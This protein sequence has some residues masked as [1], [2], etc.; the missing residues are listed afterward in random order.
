[1]PTPKYALQVVGLL[2]GLTLCAWI[3]PN[4]AQTTAL[5]N[6]VSGM[7]FMYNRGEAEVVRDDYGQIGEIRP[8][9]P[10]PF[11]LTCAITGLIWLGAFIRTNQMMAMLPSTPPRGLAL[12]V[13]TTIVSLGL[14]VPALL[15]RVHGVFP[16]D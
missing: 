12:L 11:A 14:M 6:T 8:M 16:N 7:G 3:A 13:R 9:K 10:K 4:T 5:I 2:G 15:V 1:M